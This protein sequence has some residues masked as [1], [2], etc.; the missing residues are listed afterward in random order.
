MNFNNKL[1][2]LLTEMPHISIEEPDKPYD[3][4]VD[5][6][7]ENLKDIRY[8]TVTERCASVINS[9]ID[10]LSAHPLIQTILARENKSIQEFRDALRHRD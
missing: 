7:F 3:V 1:Q 6:K 8:N 5:C 10:E 2:E 4:A 9:I